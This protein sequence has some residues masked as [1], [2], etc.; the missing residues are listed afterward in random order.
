MRLEP[1]L[2]RSALRKARAEPFEREER[3]PWTEESFMG[4]RLACVDVAVVKRRLAACNRNVN[5]CRDNI[6]WRHLIHM[7]ARR[8]S[9]DFGRFIL[10]LAMI[11]EN[12]PLYE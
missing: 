3:P 7:E 10:R 8:V 4:A 1:L 5:G 2:L 9:R 12:P 11:G 6:L